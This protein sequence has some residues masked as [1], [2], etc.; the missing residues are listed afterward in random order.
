MYVGKGI[1]ALKRT[2]EL[3]PD[4]PQANHDLGLTYELGLNNVEKALPYYVKQLES[5]PQHEESLDRMGR[6]LPQWFSRS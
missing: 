2:L 6:R 4:H 3:S 1:D 5:N